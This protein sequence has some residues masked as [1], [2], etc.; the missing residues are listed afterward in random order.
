ME[1]K[2]LLYDFASGTEAIQRAYTCLLSAVVAISTGNKATIYFL[3]K[4]VN[5]LKK[6]E[7]ERVALPGFP[8]LSELIDQAAAVG[9]RLEACEQSCMF[10]GLQASDIISTVKIVGSTTVND[11]LIE[12][13]SVLSL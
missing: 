9:V 11:R 1:G 12:A 8:P 4:G 5:I 13:D 3:D 6:N 10:A 2:S 7:S